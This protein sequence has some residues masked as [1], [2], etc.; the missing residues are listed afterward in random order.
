MKRWML[1]PLAVLMFL[2]AN[3][4]AQEDAAPTW[5]AVFNE[6]VAPANVAAF[7]ANS[8]AMHE[9]IL[10]N[11]PEGMVYYTL[12]GPES[13]YSYAIPMESMADFMKMNEQWMGMVNQIGWEKWEEMQ[14]S[15]L[16]EHS[17]MNF[18]VE[19]PDASYHPEGY[20]ESLP[21]KPVRHYDWL[22][23]KPGMETEVNEM[24][25]EWVAMYAE[26]G[27]DS[28]WTAY[29]AVTGEDLP[30]V[31][32]IT[33]AETASAY[34]MMSEEV[35]EMLGEAGQELM[36]KSMSMLRK[37]EHNEQTYRPDLSL[38]PDEM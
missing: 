19:M 32:L 17:S 5:W 7:E 33:P 21:D 35:D 11:A 18:Y 15:D 24:L 4:A 23:P 26:H 22:Y 9:V 31:V 6:Q 28:G 27:I 30:L 25:K 29:Q 12:S 34:Y 20:M 10:A 36:M 2:P 16:V 14:A 38:V 1:L 3:L 13:G 37:F 8:A